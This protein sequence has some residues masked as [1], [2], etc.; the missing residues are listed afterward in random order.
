MIVEVH[1]QVPGDLSHPRPG[2]ML[3]DT[4][5]VNPPGA[6]LDH[7]QDLEALQGNGVDAEE[8]ACQDSG[9]LGAQEVPPGLGAAL[10]SRVNT[11]AVQD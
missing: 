7:E 11:G 4:E 2:R 9:C 5:Q 8:V 6:D 3:G 1:D 10:R